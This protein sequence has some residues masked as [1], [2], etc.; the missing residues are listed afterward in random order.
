MR[1]IGANMTKANPEGHSSRQKMFSDIPDG[2]SPSLPY[3]FQGGNCTIYQNVQGA[4]A[5]L[6]VYHVVKAI[7]KSLPAK[8]DRPI[9]L[10]NGVGLVEVE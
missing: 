6:L 2:G 7:P 3:N 4:R 5:T 8:L 1:G 10:K 9:C